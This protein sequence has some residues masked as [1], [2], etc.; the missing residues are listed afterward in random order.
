MGQHLHGYR[1]PHSARTVDL[2]VLSGSSRDAADSVLLVVDEELYLY[3]SLPNKAGAWLLRGR[4]LGKVQTGCFDHPGC[5][6]RR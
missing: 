3:R 5:R 4:H 6:H 2:G 1:E